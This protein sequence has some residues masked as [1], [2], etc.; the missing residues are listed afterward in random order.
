MKLK[1]KMKPWKS[2]LI[3]G[4]VSGIFNGLGLFLWDYFKKEPLIW[5]KY[6]L[7]AIVFGFLMAF[8]FRFKVTKEKENKS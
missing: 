7:Q 8:I 4:L 3:L 1:T 6:I 2:N 5:W